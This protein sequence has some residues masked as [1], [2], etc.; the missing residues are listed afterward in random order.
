VFVR[1]ETD[2]AR[3]TRPRA[4]RSADLYR[5]VRRGCE[6][7]LRVAIL[8]AVLCPA[9]S[10]LGGGV[11]GVLL[12]AT[13]RLAWYAEERRASSDVPSSVMPRSRRASSGRSPNSWLWP[14]RR[15]TA[16]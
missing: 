3:V 5:W 11:V 15:R 4:L 16:G 12:A 1:V 8:A 6:V 13:G 10:A 7:A 14:P 2:P 9:L